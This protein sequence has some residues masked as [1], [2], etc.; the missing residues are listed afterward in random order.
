MKARDP[1][2]VQ[3][4]PPSHQLLNPYSLLSGFVHLVS[5][6]FCNPAAIKPLRNGTTLE[7][8]FS[9]ALAGEFE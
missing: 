3:D 2:P 6:I 8:V 4:I 7:R 5:G 1:Y 9:P